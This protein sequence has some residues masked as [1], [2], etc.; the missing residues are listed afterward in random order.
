MQ[1]PL[2]LTVIS[3][4]FALLLGGCNGANVSLEEWHAIV[5]DAQTVR[6]AT[7]DNVSIPD[8]SLLFAAVKAGDLATVRQLL[9]AG[10]DVNA[11]K[12][13]SIFGSGNTVLMV[14]VHPA[15]ETS[16]DIIQALLDA[17]A[18]VNGTDGGGTTA[19]MQAAITGDVHLVRLLLEAGAHVNAKNGSGNT[20]LTLAGSDDVALLQALL[21]AG[22]DINAQNNSGAS[23]LMYAAFPRSF[24]AVQ[25]LLAAGA[26]VNLSTVSGQTA[27]MR[28][29][30]GTDVDKIAALLAAGAE[31][32]A[33]DENGQTALMV[34]VERTS[35]SQE[36]L[37]VIQALLDAGADVN[38]A[39]LDGQTA[40]MR[41]A[42]QGSAD[43]VTAL[44][45]AGADVNLEDVDGYTALLFAQQS[46]AGDVI[47][48]LLTAGALVKDAPPADAYFNEGMDLLKSGDLEEAIAQFD[49]VIELK[50]DHAEAYLYRG[51]AYLYLDEFQT[52]FQN[53][54]TAIALDA[55]SL[56]AYQYRGAA[57]FLLGHYSATL[58][59]CT[60]AISLSRGYLT[61]VE[62]CYGIMGRIAA[63]NFDAVH[64]AMD[65]FNTAIEDDPDLA[66]AYLFRGFLYFTLGD[67][68][69]GV[70]DMEEALRLDSNL[71]TSA[72][73]VWLFFRSFPDP[74][75]TARE[76]ETAQT[77]IAPDSPIGFIFS[78]LAESLP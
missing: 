72:F 20:A 33:Q 48:L 64:A 28:A 49:T 57:N 3:L 35:L 8:P 50:P 39:M 68:E 56:D 40:L 27:L 51:I 13:G 25:V 2:M 44:L 21:D 12:S 59:D 69:T 19:L 9:D 71:T 11:K 36:H 17:G 62:L 43:T 46:G 70:R 10:A 31:I 26:D 65:D 41:A 34:S 7:N 73:Y 30:S 1:V 61:P 38:L 53:L 60:A 54:T 63:R 37:P 5:S 67:I 47:E 15:T 74:A 75:A 32:D 4:L 18:D 78:Q 55:Q 52:A 16:V 66:V 6:H 14:A 29:A 45:A 77:L 24:E 23:A 58:K 42:T 22:A 76:I